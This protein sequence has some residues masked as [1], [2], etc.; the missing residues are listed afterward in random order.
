M[1]FALIA[2]KLG[3]TQVFG[4]NG[5]PR[6]VT[7]LQAGPCKVLQAKKTA[8]DGYSAAKIGFG[9]KKR[10]RCSK[11]ELGA[12]DKAGF[13]SYP[14]VVREIRVVSD[15]EV[16]PVGTDIGVSV[17]EGTKSVDVIGL[18]KGRGFMGTVK[19]HG[20]TMGPRTHGSMNVRAPGSVGQHQDPAR[21]FPGKR[22]PGHHGAARRT[23]RNLKV[24]KFD[25]DRNLMF[26]EGAVPGANGG[27]LIVRKSN[28][29]K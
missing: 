17:F 19:R 12:S 25:K 29:I 16:P 2:K 24:A 20:F 4:S 15:E 27:Y 28:L 26:V 23:V 13:P 11:P 21:V 10:T 22:L 9:E 6:A 5:E 7:V 3:M 18:S 1:L 14:M 8:T